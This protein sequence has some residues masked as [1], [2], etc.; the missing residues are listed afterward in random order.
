MHKLSDKPTLLREKTGDCIPPTESYSPGGCR[1]N[2]KT[3]CRIY[4]N[5]NITCLDYTLPRNIPLSRRGTSIAEVDAPTEQPENVRLRRAFEGLID[6]R[7]F[8]FFG[9]ITNRKKKT[10]TKFR[11]LIYGTYF[12]QDYDNLINN[13]YIEEGKRLRKERTTI[14]EDNYWFEQ[15]NFIVP[16]NYLTEIHSDKKAIKNIQKY[17]NR[18]TINDLGKYDDIFEK[19]FYEYNLFKIAKRHGVNSLFTVVEYGKKNGEIHLHFLL[20]YTKDTKNI[21]KHRYKGGRW[22]IIPNSGKCNDKACG[23]TSKEVNS[24]SAFF[25]DISK[26]GKSQLELIRNPNTAR[27]YVTKYVL[28]D[29]YFN[30]GNNSLKPLNNHT[31]TCSEK[32]KKSGHEHNGDCERT[33]KG[34]YK[35]NQKSYYN[36][37]QEIKVDYPLYALKDLACKCLWWKTQFIPLNTKQKQLL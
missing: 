32:Y 2:I 5:L 33:Y 20:S 28:K 19:G 14:N 11:N 23:P 37:L 6:Q 30:A 12:I 27:N 16:L 10:E 4:T 26:I 1:G 8:N 21:H 7:K 22:A 36:P 9:T 17:Q 29:I 13:P 18:F 35:Y 31:E 34:S 3:S 25:K 15:P 24:L